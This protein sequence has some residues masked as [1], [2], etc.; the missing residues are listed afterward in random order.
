L[1]LL[2]FHKPEGIRR[3]GGPAVRWLDSA[4]GDVMKMGIGNYRRKSQDEEQWRVIEEEEE[5]KKE[6]KKEEEDMYF[7]V[8]NLYNLWPKQIC[9]T[10]RSK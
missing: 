9:T 6:R 3:V 1:Q 5:R 4:E 10:E 7:M 8:N 2:T